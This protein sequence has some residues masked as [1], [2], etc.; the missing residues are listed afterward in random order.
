[1]CYNDMNDNVGGE[2]MGLI[3]DI[4]EFALNDGGGIRTTV[5]FK[6][7]PLRCSWCH[8]PEG[9]LPRR[10]LTV[11]QN[12][13]RHCGLCFRPCTH[14]D[15]RGLGRCLHICPMDLVGVAG[16]EWEAAALAEHLLRH[17]EVYRQTG[18]GVTL[19]GGEPLLQ[20][21]FACELLD[22]LHGR[23]HTALE[24]SGFAEPQAFQAVVERCDFVFMDLK[25]MDRDL[26]RRYTGVEN[27]RILRNAAW[28]RKSGKPHTFR[29]PLIP[30]ITDTEENLAAIAAFVGSDAWE[31]LPYNTLAPAKYASVGRTFDLYLE[32]ANKEG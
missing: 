16:K 11:K 28:L 32:G 29:T 8:N 4:K 9:L 15:C 6:G 25:L 13:C 31:Q 7:C 22:L 30:R 5:F 26:H 3:F 10:E 17:A 19:S 1:M 27:D 24:T 12:G 20:W 21:E 2:N 23:T 18:G 14:E